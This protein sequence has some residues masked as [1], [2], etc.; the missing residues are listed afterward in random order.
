MR[1]HAFR[2]MGTEVVVLGPPHRRF[3]AAAREVECIFAEEE[4]RCS[5]F[6]SDSELSRMNAAAGRR[7]RISQA[8]AAHLGA[9]LDAAAATGGLFDPSVLP[10]LVAAGYDRDFDELLAG[11]RDV[12]NPAPACGRWRDIELEGRDVLL[13]PGVAIDLGGIAKGRTSDRA[14]ASAARHLGWSLVS[15]GGDLRLVG[16]APEIDV[17]VDDPSAVD[18]TCARLRL[19]TG[20]LATSSTTRRSWGEGLHHLIDPRTGRPANTGVV[21]ATVWAPTCAE[22][23]VTAKRALLVGPDLLEEG[24]A[25]LLVLAS[26]EIVTS[27]VLGSIAA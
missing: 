19:E 7:I 8:L 3:D 21:Q 12:L 15:A 27:M 11:A 18:E 9:A 1:T 2:A 22:A 20:A 5:R 4:D 10:A 14:A 16:S 25:G 23:E 26:G 24:V 17:G 13:P 6:R